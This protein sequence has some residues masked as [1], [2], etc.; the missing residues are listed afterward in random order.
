MKKFFAVVL[1]PMVVWGAKA[2]Q[3]MRQLID[4]QLTF[5][6]EQYKMMAKSVPADLM[7][8]TW[9][10]EKGKLQSN[11][12]EW[13]TSGFYPGTL[14]YIYEYTK[15][16]VIREEALNRLKLQE[17][18][19]SFTGHH[20]I[21]FMI[22]CPFGNAL[23]ITGDTSYKSVILSAAEALIT[24]YRPNVQAI[25]SWNKSKTY[26][27]P[28]IIDNMMNLE[29]LCWASENGGRP[30]FR[31]IAVRHAN[32]TLTNHYR[33]DNSCF[34]VVDYNPEDGSVIK[35]VTAQGFADA[36]AWS[37][38]QTWG[39]YGFTLMYRFTKDKRYLDHARKIARFFLNHPNLPSD[40][41]PLWDFNV[42][43]DHRY[44]DKRDASS[45]AIMASGLLELARYVP[46][47]EARRYVKD[48]ETMLRSLSAAPYRSQ[49]GA[50]GGFILQHSVG[51]IPHNSEIDVPLTYADYYFIEALLRYQKWYL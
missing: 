38:G 9:D 15:D 37:R 44:A 22:F 46:K 32:T 2:Q 23:R 30:E 3:P 26:E 24:R 20:D 27:C 7:P 50:N 21:G 16:P 5:A 14:W 47:K 51:S 43:P 6:A 49:P 1:F 10:A 8:R 42:P 45:A 35:K 17:K 33:S 40:K 25:Q 34:H 12:L 41:V 4:E 29:L 48:A 11:G 28:V 13:W 39:L 31:D 36:S 19:K 18:I